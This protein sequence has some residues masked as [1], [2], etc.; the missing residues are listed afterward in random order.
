[1]KNPP[2][3]NSL[4]KA[5]NVPKANT[6]AT[7]KAA[8]PRSGKLNGKETPKKANSGTPSPLKTFGDVAA[9]VASKK[10]SVSAPRTGGG[11]NKDV[12]LKPAVNSFLKT[13]RSGVKSGVESAV[14][15]GKII[16]IS[17]FKR[18]PLE[19]KLRVYTNQ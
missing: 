7:V 15:V 4:P 5:N 18:L 12:D 8:P 2:S 19:N 9:A 17:N 10:R 6:K 13:I 1:M 16:P 14:K 3:S 11:T